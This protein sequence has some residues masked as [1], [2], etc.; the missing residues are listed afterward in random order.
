MWKCGG[1]AGGVCFLCPLSLSRGPLSNS[2]Q[3]P[4]DSQKPNTCQLPSSY[5]SL[6]ETDIHPQFTENET[7]LQ[8][9]CAAAAVTKCCGWFAAWLVCL[10]KWRLV[11]CYGW[12]GGELPLS[13]SFFRKHMEQICR[14]ARPLSATSHRH[15]YT[16]ENGPNL[17][18]F[19]SL[20]LLH[21]L[22]S[23]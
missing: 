7:K 10:F 15:T 18:A 1:R 9:N 20:H 19:T 8:L 16:H 17:G 13:L 5:P 22:S 2:S 12:G 14:L 23:T 4:A 6:P 11:F 21:L 3:L